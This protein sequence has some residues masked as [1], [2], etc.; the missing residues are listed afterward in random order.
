MREEKICTDPSF[1]IILENMKF[2]TKWNRFLHKSLMA[3]SY[4]K[5]FRSASEKNGIDVDGLW[6]INS[7]YVGVFQIRKIEIASFKTL[8]RI[9]VKSKVKNGGS[10]MTNEISKNL[11]DAHE[12][13]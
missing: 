4:L 8:S 12:I 9:V 10:K 1:M 11:L 13:C 7:S 6:N 5:N 2:K 3:F